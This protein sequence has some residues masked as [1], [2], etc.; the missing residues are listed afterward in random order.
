MTVRTSIRGNYMSLGD[1]S[2]LYYETVGDGPRP[3]IFVPGSVLSS[4]VFHHQMSHFEGSMAYRV[5]AFDSRGQGRSTGRKKRTTFAQH[6]KDLERFVHHLGLRDFVLVGWSAGAVKALSYLHQ[7]GS[8]NLKALVLVDGAPRAT[9][10]GSSTEWVSVVGPKAATHGDVDHTSDLEALDGTVPLLFVVRDDVRALVTNWSV[11][12]TP[13][14]DVVALG[15]HLMIQERPEDFNAL[16]D[17]FLAG[18]ADESTPAS[19]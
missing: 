6:G 12:H 1:S 16:L 5:F 19:R 15:P 2:K 11:R 7:F 10:T 13:H 18:L 17:R 3:I 9:T 8:A 14:A 4:R